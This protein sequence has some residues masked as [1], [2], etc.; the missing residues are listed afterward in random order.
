MKTTF[1][2]FTK[3]ICVLLILTLFQSK[4]FAQIYN[5][6]T[7]SGF[8]QDVI[9]ESGTSSLTTTTM[10]LDGVTVSNKVIYSNAF[11]ITNGIAGGG[12]A[13]NGTITGTTGNYQLAPYNGNNAVLIQR[14]ASATISL[15]TPAKYT[16]LRLLCLSTEGASLMSGVINFSDG[17]NIAL[18]NF[19]VSDWFNNNTNVVLT[20]MGRCTRATPVTGAG[21][22]PTNPRMYFVNI[23]ISCVN[24]QKNITSI[25]LN[26]ITTAGTNA[27]FPNAVFFALSGVTYTQTITPTITNPNCTTTGNVS[28]NVAGSSSP[29]SITW[30]TTPAQTG[31][32]ATNL[33]AGN[34]I[35]T[36]VDAASCSSTFPVSLTLQNNLTLATNSNA[37]ICSGAS[38]NVTT[39]SNAATYAWTANTA[40]T[41]AGINN[42]AAQNPILTPTQTT[43]Y[44]VTATSGSCTLQS[45]F[46]I[47]VNPTPTIS[48]RPLLNICAGIGAAPALTSTGTTYTWAPTN[49]VSNTS[50]LNPT[51]NPT[52]NT[53][54]TVTAA[55]GS[56]T[57]ISTFNVVV[58]AASANAGTNATIIKG[59]STTLNGTGTTGSTYLWTPAAGLSATNVLNPVATPAATTNYILTVTTAQGCVATSNVSIE[60]LFSCIKPLNAFTPN[61]DGR[62]DTWLITEGNC[63]RNIR[64]YVYNRYGSKVY[65]SE[66]YQGKWDGTY[67]GK[68]LP[69]AT[70]YYVLFYTLLDGSIVNVKGDVT[71][72]R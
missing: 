44:T 47:T 31:T 40:A 30:N 67:N 64:A 45:T 2:L 36:I 72:L 48:T 37:T 27:P 8:N 28:L 15:V 68:P 18:A 20:G 43:T 70:Y 16:D 71:I 22:F 5:P 11:R 60:V 61:G 32:S 62:N 46:T 24:R 53:T 33:T 54:Y 23:P 7:I 17:T 69:D 63:T 66:N 57:A 25:T 49:G 1:T 65:E 39:T 13:D 14:N 58:N 12:I 42:A 6:I 3:G 52:A 51:L 19:T 50:I 21:D 55:I 4:A 35:A 41:V 59:S 38:V 29:Y 26:N 56:C 10:A 9:A 34:Y